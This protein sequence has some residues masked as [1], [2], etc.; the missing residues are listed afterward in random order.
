MSIDIAPTGAT[1]G[2]VVSGVRLAE[3]DPAGVAVI[4]AAWHEHAVLI[5][6]NQNLSEKEHLAFSRRFGCLEIG[7]R[8]SG[9]P[10][11]SHLTNVDEQGQ[12]LPPEH[13]ARRFQNGNQLWHSDSSYKRVG[14]KAS[15][16]AAQV[17]PDEGGQT[18]WAD[19]RAAYD[20]L[21]KDMKDW[22]E[23]KIAVHSYR[24]S[25][26]WHGGEEILDSG[27]LDRLPPV[28][29]PLVRIHPDTGRKSLFVGR[30]ASHIQG[31]DQAQSRQLLRELTEGA[32][33]PPRVWSHR[34]M[35]GDVVMWDNRCVLHRG[36]D[37]PADAAR[38][39]RRTTVAGDDP[40]NEWAV[41]EAAG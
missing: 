23:G 33:R 37:W 40:A 3:L 17:V 24:F 39:M 38:V 6:P 20:A 22:L 34:W 11:I 2:A 25:H 41:R 29:H 18:E 15:I 21:P 1:L 14:A 8:R 36:R 35:P 30:H 12:V 19:M 9:T 26:A 5:F 32:C 13:L 10:G 31:Q 16:L 27:E 28:E 7:L 4:E